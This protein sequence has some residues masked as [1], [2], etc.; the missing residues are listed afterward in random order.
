AYEMRTATAD[1]TPPSVVTGASATGGAGQVTFNWTA[2]N[3][4]NYAAARLYRNTVNSFSG[5]T[6]VA[7]EYGAPS[8]PDSRTVTGLTAGVRYGFIEA[9]NASGVAATAVATGSFTVT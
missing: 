3:S 8:T 2:P 1:P 6:L 4:A 7:T 5:A 9:I